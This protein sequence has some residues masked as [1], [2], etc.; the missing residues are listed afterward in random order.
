M[1]QPKPYNYYSIAP[2]KTHGH[3]IDDELSGP[4]EDIADRF[5]E[6]RSTYEGCGVLQVDAS[7]GS[8]KLYTFDEV[9]EHG[10]DRANEARQWAKHCNTSPAAWGR[11]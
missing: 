10:R 1:Q 5:Y 9:Y 7:D 11:V 3:H 2:S 4:F 8:V 6:N